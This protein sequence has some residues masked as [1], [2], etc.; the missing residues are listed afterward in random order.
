MNGKGINSHSQLIKCF[1]FCD[2][3]SKLQTLCS[4]Q[5]HFQLIMNDFTVCGIVYQ[6]FYSIH[7]LQRGKLVL[8]PPVH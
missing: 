6:R 2:S 4:N 1:G 3:F 5:T 7:K 8:I